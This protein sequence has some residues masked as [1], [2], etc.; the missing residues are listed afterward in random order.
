MRGIAVTQ[1]QDIPFAADTDYTLN[2]KFLGG[3]KIHKVLTPTFPADGTTSTSGDLYIYRYQ[4]GLDFVPAVTGFNEGFQ[5]LGWQNAAAPNY[6]V[7]AD[8]KTVLVTVPSTFTGKV[9]I[10]IFAEKVADP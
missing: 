8:G 4:H 7:N 6:T 2:T 5:M 9:T 10:I 1:N 3:M